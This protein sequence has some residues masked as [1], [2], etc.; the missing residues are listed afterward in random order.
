MRP[1]M[2]SWPRLIVQSKQRWPGCIFNSTV[3]EVFIYKQPYTDLVVYGGDEEGAW[4]MVIVKGK[5]QW[6]GNMA[7]KRKQSDQGP[8]LGY[9]FIQPIKCINCQLSSTTI[10]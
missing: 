7:R 9:A 6:L 10:D 4:Q 8:G 1:S 5:G 3:L 2:G